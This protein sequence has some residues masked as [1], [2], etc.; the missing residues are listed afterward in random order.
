MRNDSY[1]KRT[2]GVVTH[3]KLEDFAFCQEL[4]R[5]RWVE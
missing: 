4:Y 5:L 3:T 1:R 2:E